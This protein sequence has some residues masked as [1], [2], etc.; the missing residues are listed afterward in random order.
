MKTKFNLTEAL[1]SRREMVINK[2]NS[3]TD[4]RFFDGVSLKG[5]MID[6]MNGCIAARVTTENSL[7]R[8]LPIIMGQVYVDHSN[9]M[10]TDM[11]T[12]KLRGQYKGTAYMALV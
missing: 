8:M 7:N 4:E 11:V 12:E 2:Y 9:V 5:F 3:L 1:A 10:A 6:V